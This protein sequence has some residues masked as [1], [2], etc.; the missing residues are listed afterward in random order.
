MWP[1]FRD[2]FVRFFTDKKFF[3]R[4]FDRQVGRVRG[5]LLTTGLASTM[6]ADQLSAAIGKPEWTLRI[7]VGSILLAGLSVVIKAGDKTPESVKAMASHI[8]EA[9]DWAAKTP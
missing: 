3:A 2:G 6:F 8:Q 9:K 4:E 5:L 7:K 1:W